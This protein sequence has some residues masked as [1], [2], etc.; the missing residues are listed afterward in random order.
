MMKW[1]ATSIIIKLKKKFNKVKDL[2]H[3]KLLIFNP[4]KNFDY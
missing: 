2:S 4:F 1:K 3:V